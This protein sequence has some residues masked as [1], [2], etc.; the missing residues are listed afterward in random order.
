MIPARRFSVIAG[1]LGPT[2]SSRVTRVSLVHPNAAVAAGVQRKRPPP[3]GSQRGG[4]SAS[5]WNRASLHEWGYWASKLWPMQLCSASSWIHVLLW[6]TSRPSSAAKCP[7]RRN[8][9]I[10]C[11]VDV[12]VGCCTMSAYATLDCARFVNSDAFIPTT[13]CALITR[14]PCCCPPSHI[15]RKYSVVC[16][17]KP[18]VTEQ[19]SI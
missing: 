1:R 9:S 13:T 3:T 17:G 11:S 5:I 6:Q 2:D 16:F 7:K 18:A 10:S 19:W 15:T 8:R 14:S 4:H 12:V